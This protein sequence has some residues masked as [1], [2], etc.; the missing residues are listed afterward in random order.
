MG[1]DVFHPKARQRPLGPDDSRNPIRQR[2]HGLSV[3]QQDAMRAAQHGLCAICR[4]PN[5]AL[6]IDHDH[7]HHP[8]RYGCP[9][10]IRGMTLSTLQPGPRMARRRERRAGHHLSRRDAVSILA[11]YRAA[12]DPAELFRQAFWIDPLPWQRDYLREDADLCVLKGRQVGCSTAGAAK[13]IHVARHRDGANAVIVSPSLKQSTE[14]L[15]KA[16]AGVRNLGLRLRKDSAS[17]LAARQ[18][19]PDHLPPRHA[20]IGTRLVGSP[21]DRR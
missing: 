5:Q 4:R 3:A 21:A 11:A 15:T 2:R 14:V 7:R 18:R 19:Q 8:G 17:T 1:P 20:P 9:G 13:A 10:C 6:Q 12:L 16:R